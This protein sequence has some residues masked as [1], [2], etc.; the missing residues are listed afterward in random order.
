MSAAESDTDRVTIDLDAAAEAAV[1]GVETPKYY[2]DGEKQQLKFNC[3]ACHQTTDV[4]TGHYAGLLLVLRHKSEQ[5]CGVCAESIERVFA[6][7]CK[8]MHGPA[9]YSNS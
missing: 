4:L 7:N 1:K 2:Y 8:A 3:T 6:A 9:I 5:R